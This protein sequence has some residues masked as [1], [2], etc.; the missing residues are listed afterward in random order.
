MVESFA[1]AVRIASS[2]TA[3]R[4]S[5]YTG[6]RSTAQEPPHGVTSRYMHHAARSSQAT[7]L[8]VVD[9]FLVAGGLK[10]LSLVPLT[11]IVVVCEYRAH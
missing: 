1:A 10:P 4:N 7:E 11:Q 2:D 3:T 9:L 5:I 8:L 6:T